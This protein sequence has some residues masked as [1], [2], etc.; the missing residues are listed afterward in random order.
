MICLY[1]SNEKG[2]FMFVYLLSKWGAQ[3][4]VQ[5]LNSVVEITLSKKFVLV[6]IREI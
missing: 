5:E 1:V 3:I 4:E 2:E 6:L